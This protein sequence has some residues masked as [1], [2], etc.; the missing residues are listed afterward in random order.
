[1]R[2]P[3]AC[4]E[5]QD[6]G[7]QMH[8]ESSGGQGEVNPAV[9]YSF[10]QPTSA[11]YDSNTTVLKVCSWTSSISMTWELLEMQI[12]G[13]H[14]SPTGLEPLGVGPGNLCF[15]LCM[16][17]F[18]NHYSWSICHELIKFSKFISSSKTCLKENAWIFSMNVF[19][20]A[21]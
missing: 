20:A 15:H 12:L 3:E 4:Q 18:E 5:A 16:L 9:V 13:P 2:L 19:L 14:S 6:S 1:M 8:T 10:L 7:L 21:F 11:R 17:K